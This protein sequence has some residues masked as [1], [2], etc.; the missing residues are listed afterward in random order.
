MQA[1]SHL[2]VAENKGDER[3]AGAVDFVKLQGNREYR[4][5]SRRTTVELSRISTPREKPPQ[6]R[7]LDRISYDDCHVLAYVLHG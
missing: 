5:F 4:E 7:V 1:E 6:S 3:R 2:E